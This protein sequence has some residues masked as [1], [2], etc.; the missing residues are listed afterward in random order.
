MKKIFSFVW[1]LILVFGF[2]SCDSDRL[3]EAYQTL[4]DGGWHRDSPVR[5]DFA[6]DNTLTSANL[7]I[8]VRNL[9]NYSY[10]NVWFF[11]DITAPDQTSIRDTI[12][13]TLAEPDG[14]W[15]GKGNTLY[16]NQFVFR[17]NVFFP[18]KGEYSVLIHQG[19]RD[20]QLKGIRDIGLR[21]ERN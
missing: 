8:N 9:G 6:I 12:E 18:H 3:Y 21:V 14:R 20:I 15:T 11:V 1:V 17:K 19:M 7:L 13:Y 10:S 5:F 16:S 4:P 2:V